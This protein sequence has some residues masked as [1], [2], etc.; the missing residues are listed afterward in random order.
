MKNLIQKTA[1]IVIV[2]FMAISFTTI[3]NK[4]EVKLKNS[5]VVW[6]GY[7]ITGSHQGLIA[8]KSGYIEFNKEKLTGGE[9]II[10]MP[11]ITCTDLQGESKRKLEGHLKS[12]DFFGVIKFPTASLIFTQVKH[13]GGNSY[14]VA[15]DITIKGKT[16]NISFNISIYKNKANASLTIDRT[17]FNVRYGSTSFVDGLKDKAIYDEFNL[18]VD[19][20]F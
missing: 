5:N 1:A 20:E 6:T 9:F 2:T 10:D 8:I 16:E 19:L 11:S 7:K 15:G 12:D 17:K 14:K 3:E 4:K 13:T 18:D